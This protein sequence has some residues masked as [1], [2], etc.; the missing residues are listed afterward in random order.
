MVRPHS[1]DPVAVKRRLDIGV[2]NLLI[3]FVQNADEARAAVA[4]ASYPPDGFRGL[5]LT[6]RANAFGRNPNYLKA[7]ARQIALVAQMETRMALQHL[8][9]KAG[10]DVVAADFLGPSDLSA[11]LGLLGKPVEPEVGHK[12]HEAEAR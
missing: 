3:P 4:A 6:S 2:Q 1:D 11:D 10:V 5:K 8:E 7:G 9:E 12:T